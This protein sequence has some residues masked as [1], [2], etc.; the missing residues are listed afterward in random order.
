MGNPHYDLA[1]SQHC[2]YYCLADYQEGEDTITVVIFVPAT[3]LGSYMLR[4]YE[5]SLYLH[6][7]KND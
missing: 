4:I 3:V 1:Q 6:G 7:F 2:L 5:G